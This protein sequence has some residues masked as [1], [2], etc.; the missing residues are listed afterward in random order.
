MKQM[1]TTLYTE[2]VQTR[3][4]AGWLIKMCTS[5]SLSTLESPATRDPRPA[6]LGMLPLHG[7]VTMISIIILN[8][9][10]TK[11]KSTI[12][13]K[14]RLENLPISSKKNT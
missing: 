8:Y 10:V 11:W 3:A 5:A 14:I 1:V 4:P 13:T 9:N 7:T 6:G 2:L 12:P